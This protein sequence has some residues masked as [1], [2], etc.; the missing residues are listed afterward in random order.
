MASEIIKTQLNDAGYQVTKVLE[1]WPEDKQDYKTTPGAMSPK[2]AVAHLA[3]CYIA[4]SEGLAGIEH[5]WGSYTPAS[6][7]WKSL[8]DEMFSLRTKAVEELSAS[9]SEKADSLATNF[10][11][12]HDAYHVGQLCQAR[13]AVQADWNAYSIY[14]WG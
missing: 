13:L 3:E 11:V 8:T 1:G 4:T 14:N 12:L 5:K 9:S 10:I 2:E 7:D 6:Q